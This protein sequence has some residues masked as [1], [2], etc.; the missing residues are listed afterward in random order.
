MVSGEVWEQQVSQ[1]VKYGDR[2]LSRLYESDEAWMLSFRDGH[3]FL[4]HAAQKCRDA[5]PSAGA[6]WSFNMVKIGLLLDLD[7]GTLEL[8]VGDRDEATDAQLYGPIVCDGLS[9]PLIWVV[10]LEPF[11]CVT[12]ASPP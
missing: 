7:E 5:V 4:Y 9:P 8:W 2:T 1:M 12:L 6:R 3:P 11:A 10:D